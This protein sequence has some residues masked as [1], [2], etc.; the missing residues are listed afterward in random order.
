M[1]RVATDSE[2]WGGQVSKLIDRVRAQRGGRL[3][4]LYRAL[5][6]SPAV[7]GGWL[8]LFTAIRQRG[9][10]SARHRELAILRVALLTG[11]EYEYRAHSRAALEVGLTQ[12]GI[13]ALPAWRESDLFDGADRAVLELADQMTQT[14]RIEDT[15][16]D[17]LRQYFSERDVV[18]LCVTIAG[19]N[20]VSRVLIALAVDHDAP[21]AARSEGRR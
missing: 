5:L 15:L 1:A 12:D 2:N 19:Y 3:P 9:T 18:E 10:L 17:V 8:A 11:A 4:N 16:F 13:D 6:H 14:I 21:E 7:A 20:M